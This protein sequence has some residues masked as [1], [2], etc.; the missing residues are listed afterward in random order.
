MIIKSL[1]VIFNEKEFLFGFTKNCNLIYSKEN[2]KGKTTLVRFLLYALGYQI[3]ATEGIGDFAKFTFILNIT[4]NGKNITITRHDTEVL[5]ESD[6]NKINYSLPLEEKKLLSSIFEIEEVLVLN[7]LLAVFYIDQEKGWTM[8]NRGKIIGNIRFNIEEFIAGL[9]GKDICSYIEEKQT[10][11]EELK[12][13]RYFKNVADINEEYTEYNTRNKYAE[14]NFNELIQRQKELTLK[15]KKLSKKI[16]SL[17][18]SISDNKNFADLICDFGVMIVHNGE[19]IEITKENLINYN[20]NQELL[21]LKRRNFSI[22]LEEINIEL[23]KLEKEITTKN[24]L[25]SLDTILDSLESQIADMNIDLNSI[26]K[27]ITQLT[28]KRTQINK[29][30][31]DKLSFNNSH[32]IEFYDIISKYAIE[33]GIKQYIKNDSPSFVLTNKLK[34]FSGRVLAQMAYIFKLAYIKSIDSKYGIKLPI[35]IDSPRTNELS[36]ASTNDMIEI[37]K[38]DFS[39]HQIILASI[40]KISILNPNIIDFNNVLMNESSMQ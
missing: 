12:K 28:N 15:K 35:I 37:L 3:P 20:N 31:K 38:R 14:L 4:I 25:F 19:E 34:G 7:N 13:Y 30:I 10:I 2:S 18:K 27:I 40:Y 23:K 8:L 36:E 11:N 29:R 24:T 26:D 9:S 21:E 16:A 17:T 32:L 33:L 6:N 5:L 1:K 22:E 39:D